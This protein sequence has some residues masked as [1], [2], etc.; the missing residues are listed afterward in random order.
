MLMNNKTDE[1]INSHLKVFRTYKEL[2]NLLPYGYI[3]TRISKGQKY[4]F[5]NKP[6]LINLEKEK[7]KH[8]N[9]IKLTKN[10]L[11]NKNIYIF[12]D[13]NGKNEKIIS[14]LKEFFLNNKS[15]KNT[16]IK[17]ESNLTGNINDLSEQSKEINNINNYIINSHT[18]FRNQN[19]NIFKA[20]S[21][22]E[23]NKNN[24][25]IS[26]NEFDLI[27]N[28]SKSYISKNEIKNDSKYFTNEIKIHLKNLSIN[29]CV[30][31][32]NIF[33]PSITNRLKRSLPRYQRQNKG[34]LLKGY[35]MDYLKEL[36]K[37]SNN[38]DKELLINENNNF[39]KLKF[40]RTDSGPQSVGNFG[41]RDDD[42]LIKNIKINRKKEKNKLYKNKINN[43][44]LIEIVGIRRIIK[45]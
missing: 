20:L 24:M 25:N 30:M 13:E 19:K 5:K 35:G 18:I 38:L 21:E 31:R 14:K 17:A 16:S 11:Y 43:D 44:N 6:L 41:N 37:N 22:D 10:L 2:E 29:K 15:H 28:N 33:L 32:N 23:K 3:K 8:L 4:S 27:S 45:K 7:N 26:E 40:E 36:N 42:K 9:P 34:Y 39:E 12:S 1:S